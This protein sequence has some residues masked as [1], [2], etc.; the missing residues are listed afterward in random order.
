MGSRRY[1]GLRRW[2]PTYRVISR[3]FGIYKNFLCWNHAKRGPQGAHEAPGHAW[4]RVV[5]P[6]GL[7]GPCG[8]SAAPRKLPRS[9]SFQ[10]KV[11]N[12][13]YRYVGDVSVISPSPFKVTCQLWLFEPSLSHGHSR[14]G[15][16]IWSARLEGDPTTRNTSL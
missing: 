15:G 5:L 10:K 2:S 11:V 3:G 4:G 13:N 14:S 7:W 1:R 12:I 6:G 8:S 16:L 9:V